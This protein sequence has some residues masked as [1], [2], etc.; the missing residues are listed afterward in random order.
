MLSRFRN[1]LAV[2]KSEVT[3]PHSNS[4]EAVAK[5]LARRGF[6]SSV[7]TEK[8][9][10]YKMLTVVLNLTDTNSPITHLARISKP[11]RRVYAQVNK[12]PPVKHG[13]GI[14]IISTSQGVMSGDEAKAKKLGGELICEVY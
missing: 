1:A 13:R 14:I 12:I 6:V 4:K 8:G 11:G 3:M 10:S 9:E 2:G 5:V 7:K